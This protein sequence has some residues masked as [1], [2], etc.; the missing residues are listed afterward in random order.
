MSE[1]ILNTA[2]TGIAQLAMS[3]GH[4]L[5]DVETRLR[6]MW[7]ACMQ[8]PCKPNGQILNRYSL[9]GATIVR[10]NEQIPQVAKQARKTPPKHLRV[11]REKVEQA[12]RQLP[13]LIAELAAAKIERESL[14]HM[15]T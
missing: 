1:E 9:L 6:A 14:A 7:L 2:L 4:S 5:L 15:L 8:T 10:L 11:E 12:K 3:C 13:R